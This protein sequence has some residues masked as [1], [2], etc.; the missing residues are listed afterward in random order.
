MVLTLPQVVDLALRNS[1]ATR[2]TWTAARSAAAEVG[3]RRAAYYPRLDLSATAERLRQSAVGNQFSF[4]VTDYG[5]SLDLTYLLFDFGARTADVEE[6]RQ[7]LIAAG[8]DHNATLQDVVLE[9][10]TAYFQYL[11][12]K[13]LRDAQE[14]S[15]REAETNLQAA[16]DRHH[17]GVATIADVLQAKTL[18]AQSRLDLQTVVGRMQATRGSLAAALGYPA[19]LPVEVGELPAELPIEAGAEAIDALLERAVRERP[20]LA[21]ARSRAEAADRKAERIRAEG[22]PRLDLA[23]R[24]NRTYFDIAGSE[25]ANNYSLRLLLTYPLFTGFARRHDVEQAEADA[26]TARARADDL[27]QQVLVE[28]WQSYAGLETA[29]QNVGTSGSWWRAPGSRRR[30]PPAATRPAPAASSTC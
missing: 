7:A 4:Q 3:S 19:N 10:E 16:E 5:P 27:R 29:A 11:A 2:E 26:D 9:V 20:D 24:V 21:A 28:V 6:A 13:A 30:S 14:V 25:P 15:V 17:A 23:G 12:A 8:W 22:R 18:L 1:A